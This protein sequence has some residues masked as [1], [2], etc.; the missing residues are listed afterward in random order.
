MPKKEGTSYRA[1]V[2]AVEDELIVE[3]SHLDLYRRTVRCWGN[4]GKKVRGEGE[5]EIHVEWV[6]KM[7]GKASNRLAPG[8]RVDSLGYAVADLGSSFKWPCRIPVC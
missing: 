2:F 6:W 3:K 8:V 5:R 4:M 1:C 7:S